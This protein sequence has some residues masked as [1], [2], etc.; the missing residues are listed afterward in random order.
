MQ[1]GTDPRWAVLVDDLTAAEADALATLGAGG[2]LT[3]VGARQGVDERRA[4]RIVADLD[5]A[6]LGGGARDRRSGQ[7]GAEPQIA[8]LVGLGDVV[9]AR[10]AGCVGVMGLGPVGLAIAATL[11]AAGVGTLLLDDARPVR[12]GDIAPGGYGWGDVGAPRDVVGARRLR[13]VAPEVA[14]TGGAPDVLV[15]VDTDVA[16][17]EQGPRLVAAGVVHLSVVERE[18][19]VLVGPLVVPGDGACLRCLDLHRADADPQWSDVAPQLGTQVGAAAGV[20]PPT[21]FAAG[22]VL[23][24]AAVSAGLAAAAVLAHLDGGRSPLRGVTYEVVAPYALPLR[25]EWAAHPSWGC[26]APPTWSG[27]PVAEAPTV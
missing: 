2:D 8:E 10:A 18:G 22:S 5:R 20:A 12:S 16:D 24:V 9:S 17:P 19:D 21:G 26:A 23:A 13:D 14:L 25:R 3:A 27:V 15:V 4:A 1:I 6:G 11:A 7:L